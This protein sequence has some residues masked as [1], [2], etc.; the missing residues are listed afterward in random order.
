[1]ISVYIARLDEQATGRRDYSN[2]FAPNRR[3]L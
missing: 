1:M 2:R 3:Q